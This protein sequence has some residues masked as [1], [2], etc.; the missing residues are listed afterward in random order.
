M[1]IIKRIIEIKLKDGTTYILGQKVL[2][3]MVREIVFKR[4]GMAGI[5]KGAKDESHYLMRLAG[6]RSDK[7]N[8]F[9]VIPSQGVEVIFVEEELE[10]KESDVKIE[11]VE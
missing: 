9:R 7:D 1:A 5:N 4:D 3:C 10:E 8:R 2:G 11:K 6:E